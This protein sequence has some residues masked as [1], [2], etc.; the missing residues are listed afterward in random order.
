MKIAVYLCMGGNDFIPKYYLISH[1][2]IV[3]RILRK[4]FKSTLLMLL[5]EGERCTSI[6]VNESVYLELLKDLYC[7]KNLEPTAFTFD[8]V[9]QMSAKIPRKKKQIEEYRNPR[10]WLP[11][12][13]AVGQISKLLQCQ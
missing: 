3:Q 7:P 1:I 6:N 11:P 8:E 13:S 9:R 2:D 4:N 12:A 10:Q 5:F